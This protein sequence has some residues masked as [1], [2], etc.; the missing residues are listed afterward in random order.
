MPEYMDQL[1]GTLIWCALLA[2]AIVLFFLGRSGTPRADDWGGEP[3]PI[4]FSIDE[5]T[6]DGELLGW[7]LRPLFGCS[8]L[9]YADQENMPG[10]RFGEGFLAGKSVVYRRLK[11]KR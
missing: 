6:V 7:V 10:M 2:L 3:Y 5:A 1:S 9:I 11:V 8:V 4:S